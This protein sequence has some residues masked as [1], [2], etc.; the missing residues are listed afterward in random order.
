MQIDLMTQW[1][2]TWGEPPKIKFVYTNP[3]QRATFVCWPL[4]NY[5]S[6]H[7]YLVGWTLGA[8][9]QGKPLENKILLYKPIPRSNFCLLVPTQLLILQRI[10][11]GV[12]IGVPLGL[13]FGVA[14]WLLI[15][16]EIRIPCQILG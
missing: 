11:D 12:T 10:S 15:R 3:P 2:L 9:G 7:P 6:I 14:S 4:P 16:V 13:T 8:Q 5:Q 1:A